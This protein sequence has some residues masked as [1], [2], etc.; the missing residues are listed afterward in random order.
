MIQLFMKNLLFL[1]SLLMTLFWV[2]CKPQNEVF[3]EDNEQEL[4]FSEDALVFDTIFAGQRTATRRL[5]V[6][7][8]T[9]KAFKISEIRLGG[10]AISPYKII[11][12]G[13]KGVNFNNID[14]F[15]F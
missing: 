3:S 14:I 7:N 12:G 11:V 2:S 8:P 4:T 13:D 9:K 15:V 1:C 5:R 10:Q 6:Y